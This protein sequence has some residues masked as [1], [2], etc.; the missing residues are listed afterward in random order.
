MSA[1][2]LRPTRTRKYRVPRGLFPPEVS[3]EASAV[4][5][6]SH[7]RKWLALIF[8]AAIHSFLVFLGRDTA[9]KA[10]TAS[11]RLVLTP[12][13]TLQKAVPSASKAP[14][15]HR[16]SAKAKSPPAAGQAGKVVAQAPAP[17]APL[18]MTNFSI[19]VGQGNAYVGGLTASSGT[20]AR[21]VSDGLATGAGRGPPHGT[22]NLSSPAIP[23]RK[24]WACPWPDEEQSADIKEVR[25]RIRVGVDRD[26]HP[27]SVEAIDNPSPAFAQA[28]KRCA[29]GENYRGARDAAG[30]S[31][32][33]LSPSLTVH[34]YR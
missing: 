21:A 3:P 30:N 5:R 8:A 2:T 13:V 6:L 9:A 4:G 19:A 20:S 14:S 22:A 33:S 18:D 31:I 25:V 32:A 27:N 15:L 34:F 7:R 10:V 29:L 28:A 17:D 26:G 11:H 23:A 1:I 16:A 24:D 12:N